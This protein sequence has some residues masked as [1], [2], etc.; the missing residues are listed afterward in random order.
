VR[1][2]PSWTPTVRPTAWS[3][4]SGAPTRHPVLDPTGCGRRHRHWTGGQHSPSPSAPPR[5]GQPGHHHV[6]V[7]I[8][9]PGHGSAPRPTRQSAPEHTT[10]RPAAHSSKPAPHTAGP[11]EAVLHDRQPAQ[12]NS[13]SGQSP[14]LSGTVRI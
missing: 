14:Q 3:I 5:T 8:P 13:Q 2:R 4:A 10:S 9:H 12:R 7:P 11:V 6:R 1:P